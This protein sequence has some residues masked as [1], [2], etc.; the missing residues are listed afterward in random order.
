[1]MKLM[2]DSL[3]DADINR[4]ATVKGAS[5]TNAAPIQNEPDC[6]RSGKFF[7][8]SNVIRVERHPRRRLAHMQGD[9]RRFQRS[10]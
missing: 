10:K 3:D 1:M 7:D 4:A 8:M 9:R 2:M 5:A 6:E